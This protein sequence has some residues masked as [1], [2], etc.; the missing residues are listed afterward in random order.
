LTDYR[1]SY[2]IKGLHDVLR[3]ELTEVK[4]G[5]VTFHTRDK[6]KVGTIVLSSQ[7]LATTTIEN[8]ALNRIDKALGSLC[9]SYNTEAV[10][11]TNSLYVT[12]L[13][14]NPATTKVR[15]SFT[16]RR[17]GVREDPNLT[18]T[19][20]M[21]FPKERREFLELALKYYKV[22]GY[23][24][25]IRIESLFACI[26][27]VVRDICG[28]S[29]KADVGTSDLKREVKRIQSQYDNFNETEFENNWYECYT[30]ERHHGTHGKPSN[31]ADITKLKKYNE[32]A[33]IAASWARSV[34]YY[35]IDTYCEPTEKA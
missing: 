31:V 16:L 14:N 25:S 27:T 20:I 4:I 28:K 8:E 15:G 7:D 11:N 24:N 3:D 18:L 29:I 10:V 1:I 5:D 32:L 13:T 6:E 17:S 33:H 9:F 12:D 30:F 26:S 34:L 35:Y 2:E 21:S 22:S 23:E 19:K